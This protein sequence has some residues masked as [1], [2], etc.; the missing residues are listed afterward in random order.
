MANSI[1]AEVWLDERRWDALEAVLEEQGTNIEQHLQDYLLELYREMV[2]PDQVREIESRIEQERQEE[3]REA[4]ARKVF[5][6]FRLW[7]H[8]KDR[9]IATEFPVETLDTALLLRLCLR[10]GTGEANAFVQK[11]HGGCE[12]PLSKFEEFVQARVDNSGQVAGVFELV[13][14]RQVF[15][16]VQV[17]DG[18]KSYRFQDVSAA[19]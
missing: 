16:A 9:C 2:P 3:L 4:E 13:F 14:D 8:G 12:I 1:S 7:E 15:S 5:S 19:A 11:I 6:A 10:D 18:W 17:M